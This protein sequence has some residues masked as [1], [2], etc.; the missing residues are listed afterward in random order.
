MA[1][2]S[3]GRISSI[4]R[5]RW[6]EHCA[7]SA[8]SGLRLP[9]G[10]HLSTLAI[11]TLAPRARL[12]AASI[13]SSSLPACPTKGSPCRS[14]S[15]PGASPTSNQSA[16]SSPTPNTVCVRDL[17]SAQAVHAGTAALSAVQSIFA[18]RAS[19]ATDGVLG[20]PSSTKLPAATKFPGGT[21]GADEFT[22]PPV[23]ILPG[24]SPL[25]FQ[26]GEKPISRR[27]A[28]RRAFIGRASA[29]AHPRGR[30]APDSTRAAR[31]SA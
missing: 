28:S 1:R 27:I 8:G 11:Y 5:C 14:S 29:P 25:A 12:I 7:T 10:R 19:L 26:R 18:I 16:F 4:C 24:L 31:R 22:A 15:A 2:I 6:G 20:T 3:R 17:C 9:G 21:G 13:A 23:P 30:R